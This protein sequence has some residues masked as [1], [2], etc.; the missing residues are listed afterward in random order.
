MSV[1]LRIRYR[2]IGGHVHAHFWS[3]EFGPET[4]HGKNGEL[5]FR[6]KEW[7]A[8]RGGLLALNYSG[9]GVAVTMVDEDDPGDPWSVT[10]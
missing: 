6:E 5:V 2:H 8:V 3:S 9:H 10:P 7:P 1:S 4:S